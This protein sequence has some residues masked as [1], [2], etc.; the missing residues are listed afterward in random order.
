MNFSIT[1]LLLLLAA[2]CSYAAPR[3]GKF[4]FTQLNV[5]KVVASIDAVY[6]HRWKLQYKYSLHFFL[7]LMMRFM[8]VFDVPIRPTFG[9]SLVPLPPATTPRSAVDTL[10]LLMEAPVSL[11]H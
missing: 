11:S 5:D 7:Q 1:T 8:S 4:T 3:S 6:F 2:S 10:G 9:G